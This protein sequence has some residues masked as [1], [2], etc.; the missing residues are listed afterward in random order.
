MYLKGFRFGILLQ[1]SVGPV[2]LFVFNVAGENGFRAGMTAVLAV[3]LVDALYITLAGMGIASVIQKERVQR[4]IR[5]FGFAVLLFFGL[6]TILGALGIT[7]FSGGSLFSGV[8]TESLFLQG[9]LL[10]ASNPLTILFWGGVFSSEAVTYG[11][12]KKQIF[13]YGAGCVSATV[14]FLT[15]VSGI[16][17]LLLGALPDGVVMWMNILVGVLL[18]F[19]GVRLLFRKS[20]DPRPK[21]A[22]PRGF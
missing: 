19:F 22:R 4:G 15:A 1:L 13:H 16:A 3:A 12:D 17:G 10:T 18:I 20:G 14:V 5:I 9:I 21:A 7:L 2:C 6:R 8:E 11:M